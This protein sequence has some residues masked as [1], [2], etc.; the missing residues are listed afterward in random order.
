MQIYHEFHLKK[1]SKGKF[2]FTSHNHNEPSSH[3]SYNQ[4]YLGTF[5]HNIGTEFCVFLTE[6]LSSHKIRGGL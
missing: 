2:G 4:T 5:C 6:I 1:N 3:E